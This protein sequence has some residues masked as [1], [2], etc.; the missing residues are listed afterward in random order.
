MLLVVFVAVLVNAPWVHQAYVDHRIDVS[1]RDI[2]A[3]VV[4]HPQ[5]EGRYFLRYRI[6]GAVGV[7]SARVDR[8]HYD[9][10]VASG[11]VPARV[12]PG[13]PGDNRV[14]GE[15][16]SP[17]FVLLAVVADAF[18]AV[19]LAALVVRRRRGRRSVT[20]VLEAETDVL[21]CDGVA[22]LEPIDDRRHR[23]RGSITDVGPGWLEMT[24]DDELRVRVLTDR[25]RP[26]ADL[27]E[28]AEVTGRLQPGQR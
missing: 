8:A 23:L 26:R 15:E 18:L 22:G 14:P 24:V 4:A 28:L 12:V 27:R 1:G 16:H 19:A 25:I 21:P 13:H 7:Y 3:R 20:L 6:P 2:S 10:A 9:A 17:G 11:H 5:V